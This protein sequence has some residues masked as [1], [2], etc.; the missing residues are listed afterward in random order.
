[1]SGQTYVLTVTLASAGG[2]TTVSSV[3]LEARV[4]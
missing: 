3:F 4:D 2:A 1:V